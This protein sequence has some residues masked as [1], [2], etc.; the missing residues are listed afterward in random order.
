MFNFIC[1]LSQFNQA[2]DVRYDKVME[3]NNGY[4]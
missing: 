3:R 4:F 2:P 1:Y